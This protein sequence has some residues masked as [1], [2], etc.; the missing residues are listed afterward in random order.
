MTGVAFGPEIFFQ[1]YGGITRYLVEVHRRLPA[2]GVQSRV[3]AGLHGNDLLGSERVVG[4]KVPRAL[5]RYRLVPP[6]TALNEALLR[7]WLARQP[8]G[9]IYHKTYYTGHGETARRGP[10]VVTMHDLIHALFP[11]HFAADDPTVAQ[12][13]RLAGQADLLLAVSENTRRDLVQVFGV[14]ADK[15]VVTPLGVDVPA[16]AP[17]SAAPFAEPYLLYLGER[18][19]YKNW[20]T[21]VTGYARSRARTDVILVCAGGGEL[22]P[23]ERELLQHLGVS[24]RVVQVAADDARLDQLYRHAVAYAYPSLYEG[25]GLPPLEALARGCPVV[26]ARAGSI[27]E[28]LGEAAAYF[29]PS[30]A[31]D[32]AALL[33]TVVGD[34]ALRGRLA[35]GGP[36]RAAGFSWDRTA[37]LTATA[38]RRLA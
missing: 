13:R 15:V 28:V 38:Y 37:A 3:F 19:G 7:R 25:F 11:A 17:H 36:G 27:P 22:R 12:Q 2:H 9:T 24:A 6:R 14:D 21:L 10:L 5:D 18:G 33:D 16:A 35:Q 23:D 20:A 30:D 31:D 4:R 1:R 34:D 32:V 26:A 29:D 8:A